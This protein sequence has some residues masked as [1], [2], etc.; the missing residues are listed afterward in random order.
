MGLVA[1]LCL[2]LSAPPTR[3]TDEEV[4]EI[5][6]ASSSGNPWLS[7]ASEDKSTRT[8]EPGSG[9]ATV[10]PGEALYS[11]R[12]QTLL[13]LMASYAVLKEEFVLGKGVRIPAGTALANFTLNDPGKPI[14][15]MR[16]SP[17]HTAI[18]QTL[19]SGAIY[20]SAICFREVKDFLI[21][22]FFKKY[23]I[24]P[25]V[26]L[27]FELTQQPLKTVLRGE[28]SAELLYQGVGGGVLRLTYREFTGDD[29]ARPAF[30]QEVTYDVTPNAQT[31]ILFKGAHITILSAGNTAVRY[32]VD[33]PFKVSQ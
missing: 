21:P 29:L 32:H 13:K 15:Y 17:A 24:P 31:E 12:H 14:V 20:N 9:E 1:L 16:C 25:N 5:L 28:G 33:T 3:A 8:P 26:H 18:K 22:Q 6:Q 11:E 7:L 23:T 2:G 27:K 4:K 10:G 19:M 30:T